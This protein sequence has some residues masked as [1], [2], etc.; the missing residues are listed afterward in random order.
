MADLFRANITK[1]NNDNYSV[2]K[3]KME[4]LLMKEDLWSQ[5]STKKPAETTAAPSWQKRDDRA[6]ATIGLL[7][8]DSQ[9]IHIRKDTTAKG[10][11]ESLKNY[12][13]K[14]TNK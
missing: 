1:L 10:A 12:H 4:L 3:F 5:V 7:V 6:R 13:E 9:L 11:W 14:S 2:W 8:E